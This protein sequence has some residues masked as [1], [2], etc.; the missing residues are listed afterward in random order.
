MV[1]T[2]NLKLEDFYKII[3]DNE[4]LELS[5]T[6]LSKVEDGFNFLEEFRH[7]DPVAIV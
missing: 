5:E 2:A 7:D 6:L 3:F 1:L 4:T